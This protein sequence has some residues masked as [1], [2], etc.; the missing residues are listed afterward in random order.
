MRAIGLITLVLVA[1]GY[2]VCVL[3]A[4]ED[5][6]AAVPTAADVEKA[7]RGQYEKPGS[8]TSQ[9]VTVEI[10]SIK[11]GSSAAANEQDKID[12]IPPAATVTAA[13]IDYTQRTFYTDATLA[14][15]RTIVAKVFIDK[16][17]EWCVMTDAVRKTEDVRE[18]PKK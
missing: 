5:A 12:G 13:L 6:K 2:S 10:H 15:R 4:A 18:A 7:M 1:S 3:R 17:G 14:N 11:I 8:A 16:F 9:K